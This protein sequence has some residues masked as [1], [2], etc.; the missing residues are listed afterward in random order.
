MWCWKTRALPTTFAT[1]CDCTFSGEVLQEVVIFAIAT[2]V[3][4]SSCIFSSHSCFVLRNTWHKPVKT[5]DHCDLWV[6]WSSLHINCACVT[7][8]VFERQQK[9]E[10][11]PI[12][13][14]AWQFTL[15]D[16]A[17]L[18]HANTMAGASNVRC[19][20]SV[21]VAYVN[22]STSCNGIWKVPVKKSYYDA[23]QMTSFTWLVFVAA[24]RKKL[25]QTGLPL[26]CPKKKRWQD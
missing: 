14:I 18:G 2:C 22:A 1:F 3:L 23:K 17:R 5:I 25:R 15:F 9:A 21:A 16:H 6:L 4:T 26:D 13:L 20:L 10:Y 19:E 24:G 8:K 7:G 12:D 11:A